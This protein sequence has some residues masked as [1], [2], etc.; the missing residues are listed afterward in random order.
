M[1]VAATADLRAPRIL[2]AALDTRFFVC[3]F[4]TGR[5]VRR[6]RRFAAMFPLPL[7]RPA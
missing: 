2:A 5:V 6:E 1:P 7:P 3:R 4:F